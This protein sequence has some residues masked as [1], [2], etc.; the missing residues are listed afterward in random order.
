MTTLLQ[1]I[2]AHCSHLDSNYPAIADALNAPTIIANPRAGEIDTDVQD[3][4]ITLPDILAIIPPAETAIIYTKAP[5]LITNLQQAL[6]TNARSWLEY[7][8]AV[9]TTPTINAL[10]PP[11]VV[12][13]QALLTTKVTTTI[14]QPDTI[15]SSSLAVIAGFGFITP[16][17]IQ[18][19]LNA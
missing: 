8:L 11:T 5:A 2:Q 16:S 7:L 9:A 14:T 4:A 3:V 13:L 6:D 15:P 18:A 10:T 1:L 17:Q 19:C 12:A